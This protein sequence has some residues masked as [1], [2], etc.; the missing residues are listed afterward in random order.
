[1]HFVIYILSLTVMLSGS[2]E[3]TGSSGTVASRVRKKLFLSLSYY[4]A[5]GGQPWPLSDNG[6]VV[7]AV[8]IIPKKNRA[9]Y[10]F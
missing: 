2:G 10:L 9:S 8:V 7:D 3:T 1:M 6:H 4:Q 5:V